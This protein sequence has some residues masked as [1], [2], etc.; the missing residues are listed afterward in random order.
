MIESTNKSFAPYVFLF[1]WVKFVKMGY[2]RNVF[3]KKKHCQS[4]TRNVPYFFSH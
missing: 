4:F 3:S 1:L 2:T